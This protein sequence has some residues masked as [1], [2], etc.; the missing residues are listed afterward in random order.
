MINYMRTLI[1]DSLKRNKVWSVEE[2]QEELPMILD[3]VDEDGIQRLGNETKYVI[4]SESTWLKMLDSD[5]TMHQW[6][7]KNM[8]LLLKKSYTH[9]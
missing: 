3:L 4:I 9:K 8:P 6:I 7:Q 1:V 2:T 5:K